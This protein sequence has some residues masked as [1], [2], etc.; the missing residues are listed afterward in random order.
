ML[1]QERKKLLQFPYASPNYLNIPTRMDQ[2]GKINQQKQNYEPPAARAIVDNRNLQDK[3]TGL[4][5][6]EFVEKELARLNT[7]RQMPI[8]IIKITIENLEMIIRI[9]GRDK[10]KEIIR[11]LSHL[12]QDALRQEDILARWSRAKFLV[13]LPQTACHECLKI[14]S[15]LQ[16]CAGQKNQEIT[17]APRIDITLAINEN[18]KPEINDLIAE[19]EKK[20]IAGFIWDNNS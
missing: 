7:A 8:S 3:I 17:P 20:M 12:L 6:R 14:F 2:S 18:T 9:N 5:S 4:L 15:R 10:S 13:L 19:P 11:E 16:N 1:D